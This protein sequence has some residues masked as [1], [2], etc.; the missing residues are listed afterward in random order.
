MGFKNNLKKIGKS[1]LFLG[2]IVGLT[3]AGAAAIGTM[4]TMGI[5]SPLVATLAVSTAAIVAIEGVNKVIPKNKP[6]EEDNLRKNNST[7][8]KKQLTKKE[9]NKEKEKEKEVDLFLADFFPKGKTP[10]KNYSNEKS[11]Q[12]NINLLKTLNKSVDNNRNRVPKKTAN[13]LTRT[14]VSKGREL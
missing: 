5:A 11:N 14:E 2:S 4:V 6:L 3:V 9:M 8:I 7:E 10:I 13:N 12:N 1:M